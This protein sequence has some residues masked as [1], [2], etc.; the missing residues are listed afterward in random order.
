MI[1]YRKKELSYWTKTFRTMT[2]ESAL[3]AGKINKYSIN[4]GFCFGGLIL[5]VESSWIL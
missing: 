4:I 5:E 2:T 1:V 3:I